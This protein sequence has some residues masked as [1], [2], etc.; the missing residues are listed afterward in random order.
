MIA[1]TS[2]FAWFPGLKAEIV[3]QKPVFLAQSAW[4]F[5]DARQ[6]ASPLLYPWAELLLPQALWAALFWS[7]PAIVLGTI[8]ERPR[9]IPILLLGLILGSCAAKLSY[10][11]F[12]VRAVSQL[13]YYADPNDLTWPSRFEQLV[14]KSS[15]HAIGAIVSAAGIWMAFQN[16]THCSSS[17]QT[18]Q[19]LKIAYCSA[20]AAIFLW[21]I[22]ATV[23]KLPEGLWNG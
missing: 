19:A 18:R 3:W 8:T 23:A 10:T 2:L 15:A 6:V 9:A 14:L 20:V 13:A 11:M 5:A 7:V 16:Q 4:Q 1:A 22:G 17:T 12:D 21:H